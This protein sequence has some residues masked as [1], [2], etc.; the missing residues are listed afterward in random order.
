MRR[1]PTKRASAEYLKLVSD[2]Y[3][4]PERG[5][6]M[7]EPNPPPEF[8]QAIEAMGA[9]VKPDGR[10]FSLMGYKPHRLKSG[11]QAQLTLWR[12]DCATCGAPYWITTPRTPKGY[13]HSKAFGQR[14]CSAHK[15]TKEQVQERWRAGLKRNR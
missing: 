14:H 12:T 15:L 2:L 10:V 9:I 4:Q 7:T 13:A 6:Q 11:D 3:R 8:Q 5:E 1:K